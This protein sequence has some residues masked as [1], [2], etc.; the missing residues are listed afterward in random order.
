LCHEVGRQ[1]DAPATDLA[2]HTLHALGRKV[3]D[4]W[5]GRFGF[6]NGAPTAV[7]HDETGELLASAATGVGWDLSSLPLTE[8][9]SAVDRCRLAVE[10][11]HPDDPLATLAAAYD[12]QLRRRGVIDFLA[13]LSWPLRLLHE[14]A[15]L[16]QVL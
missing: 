4:T 16:R 12:E 8:L 11:A 9:A 10:P 1:L 7:H 6:S 14:D 3:I 2:I 5:P 15:Q 13:T